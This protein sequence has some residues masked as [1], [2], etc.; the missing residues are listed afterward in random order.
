MEAMRDLASL[1]YDCAG[2]GSMATSIST[3]FSIAGGNGKSL[4]PM[5]PE[6]EGQFLEYHAAKNAWQSRVRGLRPALAESG[7][8]YREM[9]LPQLSSDAGPILRECDRRALFGSH[10]LVFGTTAIPACMIEAKGK[11]VVPD[12]TEDSDLACVAQDSAEDD[13]GCGTC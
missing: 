12:A 3:E 8:L 7:A 1:T 4:G 2:S 11:F 10:L 6:L 5:T 13:D 9:R